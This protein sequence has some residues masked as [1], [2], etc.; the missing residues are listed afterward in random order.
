L[1]IESLKNIHSALAHLAACW[2]WRLLFVFIINKIFS[3]LL[4]LALVLV[5]T[6]VCCGAAQFEKGTSLEI[7]EE[8]LVQS[9]L[10]DEDLTGTAPTRSQIIDRMKVCAAVQ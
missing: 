2:L 7:P 9:S 8:K 1:D 4:R 6:A 10:Q 3:M 5:L